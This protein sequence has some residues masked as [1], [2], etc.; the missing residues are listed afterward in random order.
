MS[1]GP[2]VQT[3]NGDII[4]RAPGLPFS[5]VSPIGVTIL[6]A[7]HYFAF[8]NEYNKNCITQR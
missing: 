3:L 5:S 6:S 8:S 4:V 2:A 7:Q 1:R